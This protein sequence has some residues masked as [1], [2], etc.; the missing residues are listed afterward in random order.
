M[1]SAPCRVESTR[2]RGAVAAGAAVLRLL[3]DIRWD[4]GV[5]W[6]K[7]VAPV[8]SNRQDNDNRIVAVM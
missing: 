4:A 2:K 6:R 3:A 5:G 1:K 7:A 8:A